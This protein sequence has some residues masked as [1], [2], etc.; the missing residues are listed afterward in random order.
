MVVPV[1]KCETHGEP[2]RISCVEC[3]K[4]VCPKCMVRTEVGTKCETCA[5]PVAPRITTVRRSRLP[6]MLAFL[7]LCIIV[8]SVLAV[9]MLS[10][11][12]KAVQSGNPRPVGSWSSQPSLDTIR[13]TAAVVR[14]QNGQVLAAGGGVGAIAVNSAELYDPPTRRW[15][16][17]GSLQ[18]AR[19]GAAAVQLAD[20]RVLLV[21]GVGGA[22][23]L[24]SAEIYDPSTGRW[25]PTGSM[26]TPRLGGTLTLLRNGD[27]LAAGGTSPSGQ[28]GTGGGQTI[29]P[30]SSA[31][32]YHAATGAW[33]LTGSMT[34]ARFEASG[35]LLSDGRVLIAGGFGAS[36]VAG[37]TGGIQ[38]NP[39]ASTETYD[40]AIGAFGATG[41]MSNARA[42]HV[43][44]RLGDG[45][46]LVAGGLGGS[47]GSVSVATA[48]R[49]D[50]TTGRW[51]EVG[52]LSQAR[53][54]ASAAM[55]ANGRVLIAGGESVDQGVRNSLD[56]G[57]LFDLTTSAWLPAGLMACPRSGLAAVTLAD[58]SVL[59]VAGD[60]A[61]PGQ[62]PVAQ[63]CVERYFPGTAGPSGT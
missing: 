58:G 10:G 16:P 12:R 42:D 32:I 7:G 45:T 27:V 63:S 37:G 26:T 25:T 14:L 21:G 5:A 3:G 60:G 30:T 15:T 17:T 53:T 56:S 44:V 11:G 33:A 31:E 36:G 41:Q 49:F 55:L 61:F 6:W 22:E 23:L 34:A 18:Q 1:L 13:G 39:L 4:P 20:G 38:Y 8:G 40:P 2:T 51:R 28:Q 19:R 29:S 35:T 46:V 47:T 62:P 50:P 43:A 57:E 52:P 54:G 59:E 48:E 24:G 9:I